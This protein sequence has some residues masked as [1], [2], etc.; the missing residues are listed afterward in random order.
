MNP[1]FTCRL[2]PLPGGGGHL[3]FYGDLVY[4]TAVFARRAI[5]TATARWPEVV[6]D[7]AGVRRVDGFGVAAL[8]KASQAHGVR[9]ANPSASVREASR[10]AGVHEVLAA[11][12]V[13]SE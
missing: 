8:V 2:R 13:V 6:I 10:A 9:L 3:A 5:T 4:D 12:R 11:G 7:V 1:P